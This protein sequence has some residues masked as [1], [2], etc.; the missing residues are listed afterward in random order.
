[1]QENDQPWLMFYE[2]FLD[3]AVTEMPGGRQTINMKA[4]LELVRTSPKSAQM[5]V[6]V[7]WKQFKD[8][9][10]QGNPMHVGLRMDC[11]SLAFAY[12]LAFGEDDPSTLMLEK[13]CPGLFAE[14]A[15]MVEESH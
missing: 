12:I 4:T 2:Q 15:R 3:E 6:Q 14:T 10:V 8:S 9:E 13:F 1:M 11:C 5:T 7:L